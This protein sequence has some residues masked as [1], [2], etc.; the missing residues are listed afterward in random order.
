[1]LEDLLQD[2][3]DHNGVC[4]EDARG[5]Y[6]EVVGEVIYCSF[7]VCKNLSCHVD[8]APGIRIEVSPTISGRNEDDLLHR[9]ELLKD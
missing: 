5:W 1:M 4:Q 3:R 8:V 7:K 9:I 6:K 2:R